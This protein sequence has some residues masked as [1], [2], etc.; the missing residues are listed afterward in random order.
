MNG[1]RQFSRFSV[2][3]NKANPLHQLNPKHRSSF[4][5]PLPKV[6]EIQ[7]INAFFNNCLI[8]L[9]WT[10][11]K[12][13]D[14]PGELERQK[15]SEALQEYTTN[16]PTETTAK[17]KTSLPEI[18]FIGKT[19]V[20]K[21]SLI[22]SLL[23][24]IKDKNPPEIVFASKKAGFTQTLNCFNVANRFK[25]IDSPGYGM[26]GTSQQGEQILK[27]MQNRNELK[28]VYLLVG[29]K[30]GFND[31]DYM[32]IDLLQSLG[33]PFEIVFTKVD[34]LKSESQ[35]LTNL[36]ELNEQFP[37]MDYSLIFTNTEITKKFEKKLG[38]EELR[39]S[40]FQTCGLDY[41]VKPLKP[42]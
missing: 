7:A 42:T 13:E 34:K 3:L 27:Y 39:V 9:N 22:N 24:N 18:L 10:T 26:K 35:L 11:A 21:S 30:E 4:Q 29:A 38:I 20:G 1:I 17:P 25:L 36:Q 12:F 5:Q 40:I 2:A 16:N 23:T 8:K 41:N 37:G 19:N 28:R 31:N 33:L 6:K 15:K 14:I 32:I